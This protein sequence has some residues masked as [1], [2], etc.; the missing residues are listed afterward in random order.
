MG[1][2]LAAGA[3]SRFGGN[4]LLYPLRNGVPIALLSA[5]PLCQIMQKVIAII[6]PHQNKLEQL[7][8]NE[9]IEP[10]IFSDAEKGMG[11]S[12]SYAVRNIKNADGW[13]I[14]LADMP[15]IKQETISIVSKNLA[16]RASIVYPT[17]NGRKGHPVGI[18]GHYYNELSMLDDDSGAQEILAKH[19]NHVMEIPCND[20]GI[21]HDIDTLDDIITEIQ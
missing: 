20:P 21:L 10:V 19:K 7:F 17:Y 8:I 2:I 16:D 6:P 14:C 15:Y 11:A 4:K 12:L 3:S 5:R 9:D 1:I 18:G 13:I